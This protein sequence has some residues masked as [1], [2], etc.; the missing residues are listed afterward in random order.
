MLLR[1]EPDLTLPLKSPALYK[2]SAATRCTSQ[3]KT[4]RHKQHEGVI[5]RDR[6]KTIK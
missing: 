2:T 4:S 3:P 1:I 5:K 6:E